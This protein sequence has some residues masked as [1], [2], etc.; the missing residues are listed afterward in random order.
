VGSFGGVVEVIDYASSKAGQFRILVVPDKTDEKWPKQLRIGSG[1]K[2]WVML[3]DVPIWWELWRQLNGF[4]VSLYQ[5]P[6]PD[7]PIKKS[8]TKSEEK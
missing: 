1:T 6:E 3:N 4:P 7:K 5:E 2:G 8:E